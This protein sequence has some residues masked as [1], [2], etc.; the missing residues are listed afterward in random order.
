MICCCSD[1]YFYRL[2][3]KNHCM[4]PELELGLLAAILAISYDVPSEDLTHLYKITKCSLF[5]M[6]SGIGMSQIL[7]YLTLSP[8]LI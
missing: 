8:F 7:F 4:Y 6:I 2:F 3:Y 1:N 5:Y